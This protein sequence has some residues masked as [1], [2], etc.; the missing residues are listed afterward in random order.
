MLEKR[1][2]PPKLSPLQKRGWWVVVEDWE[3]YGFKIPKDFASDLD[4]IPHIPG[5]Y[6]AF[7]GHARWSAL[8]HDFLYATELVTREEADALFYMAML[9]EG[10]PELLAKIMYVAVRVFGASRYRKNL[11]YNIETRYKRRT[12]N[13]D[14][15]V[16][17]FSEE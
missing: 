11:K 15:E 14:G 16:P 10:V 12:V 6:V 17:C 5:I 3:I 4:S 7:K 1:L 9:E 8:L 13:A 2:T